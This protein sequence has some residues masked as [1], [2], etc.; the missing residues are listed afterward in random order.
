[1]KFVGERISKSPHEECGIFYSKMLFAIFVVAWFIWR[2][3]MVIILPV[4]QY[5]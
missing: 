5:Y 2:M 3:A 4:A 1:V